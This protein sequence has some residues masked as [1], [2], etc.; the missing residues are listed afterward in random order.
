[1]FTIQHWKSFWENQS[2]PLHR[3][4]SEEW[5]YIYAQEINLISKSLGYNGGSVMETGCGNGALFNY[6]NINKENYVGTDLSESMLNIFRDK[7]PELTLI[8]TDSSSYILPQKFS[9]VFSNGVGQYFDNIMM[10]LY[11]NNALSMLE[12]GGVL[13]LAN[14]PW[15]DMRLKLYSGEL[16]ANP[17]P[18]T[19]LKTAKSLFVFLTNQDSM[20][21]W[22]NP[23]DFLKYK[24]PGVNVY[25]FGSLFHPYRFSIGFKKA[26]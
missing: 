20:G 21:Y 26:T 2:T 13:I 10:N 17:D 6:L 15:K 23:R 18:I 11:I 14:L 25:V 22:Y 19:F 5:Y 9:M 8:C 24:N 1:M 7:H 16:A 12:E 4:N 3:Y